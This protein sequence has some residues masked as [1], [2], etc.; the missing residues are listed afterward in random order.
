MDLL[1]VLGFM[2]LAATGWLW[3][4]SLKARETAV[5]AAKA[6]CNA[7]QLLLLD[8][9]VAIQRL[10]LGRDRE[11]VMRI[12]RSYDFEY[13]DTGNDR[14]AGSI[15]MLGNRVLVINLNLTEA[16]EGKV[17]RGPWS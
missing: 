8:D 7:E 3:L 15:A 11:G 5:A 2:L 14:R 13:S 10:S 6:A 17:I 1:D 12:R 4:D 9:T 16:P